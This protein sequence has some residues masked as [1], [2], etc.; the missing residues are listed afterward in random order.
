PEI[1]DTHTHTQT[2]THLSDTHTHTHTHTPLRHARTHTH[3]SGTHTHTPLRDTHTYT[4]WEPGLP[5][6]NSGYTNCKREVRHRSCGEQNL[7]LLYKLKG[8]KGGGAQ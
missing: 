2:H 5:R 1:H 8:E 6:A 3:L 7:G 4:L